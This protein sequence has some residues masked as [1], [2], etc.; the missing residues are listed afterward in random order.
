MK[1]TFDYVRKWQNNYCFIYGEDDRLYF[2]HRS[3]LGDP[4][5]WKYVWQGNTCEF[6]FVETKE[7]RPR[8]L[9]IVPTPKL[10]TEKKLRMQKE[11]A[12]AKARREE[13]NRKAEAN[14]LQNE[15]RHQRNLKEQEYNK[16]HLV[17]VVQCFDDSL[18]WHLVKPVIYFKKAEDA[19]QLATDMKMS[20]PADMF[21]VKKMMKFII[22]GKTVLKSTQKDDKKTIMV[23]NKIE[24][25]AKK[26]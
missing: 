16:E 5:D 14:R 25:P 23:R 26:T 4:K 19:K 12:E 20:H 9:N 3:E 2:A 15:K 1:G 7:P 21:R 11:Q 6:D 22:G 13:R 17:Y 10:N 18:R 24:A 8:A